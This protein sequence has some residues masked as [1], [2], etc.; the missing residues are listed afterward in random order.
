MLTF[1]LCKRSVIDQFKE[2]C[3]RKVQTTIQSTR[4]LARVD[5]EVACGKGGMA[6]IKLSLDAQLSLVADPPTVTA[7]EVCVC[8]CVC[9]WKVDAI[10]FFLS[11]S[12]SFTHTRQLCR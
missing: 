4:R 11:P 8:V 10:I 6:D 7:V 12:Y 2:L 1:S 3:E 9:K 5:E